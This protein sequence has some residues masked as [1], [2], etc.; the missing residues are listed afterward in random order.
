M[1]GR[2]GSFRHSGGVSVPNLK[3]TPEQIA[4]AEKLREPYIEA[5]KNG[6]VNNR[7]AH[8]AIRALRGETHYDA[9]K[10][11]TF[12]NL[13]EIND[14]VRDNVQ[15]IL[16]KHGYMDSQLHDL[17]NDIQSGKISLKRGR[18][19]AHTRQKN[20]NKALTRFYDQG[21]KI[22]NKNDAKWW[23]HRKDDLKIS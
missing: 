9:L 17:A 18:E 13:Y 2:S 11:G 14:S 19:I 6:K 12:V 1:G 15:D 20:A 8:Q 22:L 5:F 10:Q 4:Q 16:Y 21:R 23:I 3:G 7:V